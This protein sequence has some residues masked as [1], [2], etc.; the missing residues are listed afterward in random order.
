MQCGVLDG[1]LEVKEGCLAKPKKSE[2]C[3]GLS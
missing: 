2:Q 3:K 1:I